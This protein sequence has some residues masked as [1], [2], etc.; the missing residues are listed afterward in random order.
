VIP[1][2]KLIHWREVEN[3]VKRI[4]EARLRLKKK[5]ISESI[6]R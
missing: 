4:K 1:E 6:I 3:E 2:E 5:R